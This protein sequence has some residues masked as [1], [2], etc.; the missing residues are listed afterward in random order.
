MNEVGMK[1]L[2]SLKSLIKNSKIFKIKDFEWKFERENYS[3]TVLSHIDDEIKE[4]FPDN[5]IFPLEDKVEFLDGLKFFNIP[6]IN[7][8]KSFNRNSVHNMTEY[9]Y[10]KD[11]VLSLCDGAILLR[12]KVDIRDTIFIPTCLYKHYVKYCSAE[13]SF[14]KENENCKLR[15][16]DKYG[17][18]ITFE[19]KNNHIGFDN[20]TLLKKYPK[21]LELLSDGNI[22]DI[23][24]EHKDFKLYGNTA[25]LVILT[26]KNRSIVIKEEYFE[27]AQKL[28]FERYRIYKDYII[29]DKENCGLVIMRCVV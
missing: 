12:Q 8:P 25:S 11:G 28:K 19:F 7:L 13:Q 3:I 21:E 22:E 9:V 6:K 1:T 4:M 5:E 18:L 23:N 2:K 15:F 24:I 17:T 27:F 16:V 14:Q 26:D 10:I 20:S 29:F